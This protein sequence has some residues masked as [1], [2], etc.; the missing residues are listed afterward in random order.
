MAD[1]PPFHLRS[2]A[3]TGTEFFSVRRAVHEDSRLS[4]TQ[5]HSGQYTRKSHSI[6]NTTIVLNFMPSANDA[7]MSAGVMTKNIP[8]N[9]MCVR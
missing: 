4:H 6:M 8:W 3:P 5:R 7:T 1:A 2:R 9:S